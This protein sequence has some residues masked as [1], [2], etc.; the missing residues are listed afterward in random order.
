MTRGLPAG[1]VGPTEGA[2]NLP[3]DDTGE[4]IGLP[5]SGLTI[6][7][8]FGPGAVPRR[9]RQ[10]PVRPRRPAAEGAAHAAALP[11]RRARPRAVVRRPLRPGVRRRPAG[12]RARDPQPGP[13]RLRHRRGALVAARLR[14]HLDHV[15]VAVDAAQPVRLQGR[16]RQHQGRGDR[17]R[18]RSTSGSAPATTRARTGWPAAPTWSPGGST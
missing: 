8:G 7:F 1:E 12:R 10:R 6:T 2:A 5:A 13:D 15:D 16:H 14:P 4:A 18:S 11:G 17:R 9:R 3:P